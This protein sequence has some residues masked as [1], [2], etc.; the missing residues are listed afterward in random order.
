MYRLIS[1]DTIEKGIY[2]CAQDKLQLEKDL[3]DHSSGS[4][5]STSNKTKRDLKKLLKIALDVEMSEKALG[6]VEKVYTEL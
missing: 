1:E 3:S 5:V 6:D 2:T 4:D